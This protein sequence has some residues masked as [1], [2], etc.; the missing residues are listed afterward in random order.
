VSKSYNALS[1]V[2]TPNRTGF[3]IYMQSHC[4]NV[5]KRRGSV[6]YLNDCNISDV[7]LPHYLMMFV[8]N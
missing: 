8:E 3:T 5:F 2:H 7:K 1:T 4:R 6:D